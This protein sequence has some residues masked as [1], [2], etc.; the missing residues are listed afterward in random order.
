MRSIQCYLTIDSGQFVLSSTYTGDI[1][2]VGPLAFLA[3]Q[4]LSKE[5]EVTIFIQR[6]ILRS[7]SLLPWTWSSCMDNLDALVQE[8]L[9]GEQ[10]LSL[11]KLM[12]NLEHFVPALANKQWTI[13]ELITSLNGQIAGAVSVDLAEMF[14]PIDEL[15]VHIGL[16]EGDSLFSQTVTEL[17][18]GL[19][20]ERGLSLI[21]Y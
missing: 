21:Y 7:H 4:G 14:S 20:Q 6:V 15:H 13:Q 5:G 19:I 16:E 3:E 8:G 10:P 12:S 1:E 2:G 18:N 11:Q 9:I 17:S